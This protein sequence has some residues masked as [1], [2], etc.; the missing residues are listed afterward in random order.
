M[1]SIY[2]VPTPKTPAHQTSRDDRLR[3]QT[4]FYTAGWD[5]DDIVLQLNL[6]CCQVLY[7]LEHQPTPQKHH[8][9]RHLLL[10][11]P[12]RKILINWVTANANNQ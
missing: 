4:L 3:I 8:C 2:H 9:G 6:T 7:A 5:I 10:D 12:K 11:T 1:E